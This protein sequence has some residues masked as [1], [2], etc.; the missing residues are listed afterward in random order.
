MN[1]I[2]LVIA[3]LIGLMIALW[4]GIAR[5][6]SESVAGTGT[7]PPA[8]PQGQPLPPS[9]N[10][11]AQ[12]NTAQPPL[13][14][15]APVRA[16]GIPLVEVAPICA[17]DSSS[18]MIVDQSLQAVMLTT[19]VAGGSSYCESFAFALRAQGLTIIKDGDVYRVVEGSEKA[20]IPP[21]PP[22]TGR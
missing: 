6:Q 20:V 14:D 21:S 8:A 5:A 7:M 3:G 19:P 10:Y 13:A 15:T 22:S 4:I 16:Q 17:A 2:S 12:P 1:R 11:T 9:F 18:S